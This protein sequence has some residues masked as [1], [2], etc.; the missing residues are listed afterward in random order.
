M[1]REAA[2]LGVP[3]YSI[4][5]SKKPYL[6]EYLA[7]QGKLVFIDDP[8]KVDQ[9]QIV[10][11]KIPEQLQVHNSTINAHIVNQWMKVIG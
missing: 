11:R 3:V 10:K 8:S 9:V 6:D 5:A 7:E 1:N 4:F 2:L